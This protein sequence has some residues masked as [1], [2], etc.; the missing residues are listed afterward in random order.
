MMCKFLSNLG[1]FADNVILVGNTHI[2]MLLSV[3]NEIL[4]DCS[5]P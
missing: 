4:S 5:L 3:L 1:K 2:F